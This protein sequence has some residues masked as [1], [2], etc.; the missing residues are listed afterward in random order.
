[1]EY[2]DE[3]RGFYEVMAKGWKRQ[4]QREEMLLGPVPRAM[5]VDEGRVERAVSCSSPDSALRGQR[6]L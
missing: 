4:Q 2:W 6:S 1:M 5:A 3:R